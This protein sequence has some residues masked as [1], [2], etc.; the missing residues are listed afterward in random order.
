M[1]KPK[2]MIEHKH[3]GF[4]A[5]KIEYRDINKKKL[6]FTETVYGTAAATAAN[7]QTFLIVPADGV[8]TGFREVHSI[9]GTD[10][11]AVTLDLEKLTGT[12]APG[13]GV[14]MLGATLSLKT[15]KDTVQIGTFTTTLANRSVVAGDRLALKTSGT[16]TGLIDVTVLVEITLK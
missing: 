9:A 6:F 11:G 5:P 16:L 10:G 7:F 1:E 8:L 4:D 3:N 13:S 14:S 2:T 12:T 15:T